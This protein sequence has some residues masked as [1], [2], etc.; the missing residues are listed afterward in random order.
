MTT[1][2]GRRAATRPAATAVKGGAVKARAVKGNA[3]AANLDKLFPATAAP[4]S[5]PAI[6]SL[7]GEEGVSEIGAWKAER[8]QA[9][10][11]PWR[12]LSLVAGL[13]FGIGSF[14]LPDDVTG[15]TD[16]LLYALSAMSFGVAIFGKKTPK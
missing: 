1:Q 15:Y 12:Q 4:P 9:Y 5:A 2:F 11:L 7:K 14:V 10:R 8:K 16:M 3:S 6:A 13:S